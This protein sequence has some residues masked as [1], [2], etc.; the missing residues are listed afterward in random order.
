MC[1]INGYVYD[2]NGDMFDMI[3]MHLTHKQMSDDLQATS[4]QRRR[5]RVASRLVEP[6]AGQSGGR[7]LAGVPL[8]EHESRSNDR[9]SHTGFANPPLVP[10]R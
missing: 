3:S 2:Y 4:T 7:T 5:G 1:T 10:S 9:P 6:S 8:A